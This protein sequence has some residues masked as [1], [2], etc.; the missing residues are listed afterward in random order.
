MVRPQLETTSLAQ[1]YFN[2]IQN[3]VFWSVL[4]LEGGREGPTPLTL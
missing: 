2:P 1:K 3:E 4:D